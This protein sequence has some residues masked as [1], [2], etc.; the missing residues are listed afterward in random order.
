MQDEETV[1]EESDSKRKRLT[2]GELLSHEK[3]RGVVSSI[4]LKDWNKINDE[5]ITKSKLVVKR[6]HP[7]RKSER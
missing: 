5:V 4:D 1:E 3:E 7:P 2:I 6:S